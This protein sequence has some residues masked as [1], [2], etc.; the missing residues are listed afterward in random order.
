MTPRGAGTGLAG[1]ATP[2]RGGMLLV[3]SRMDQVLAL[4]PVR[5]FAWVQPGL[6]NARLS[7]LAA[8]HGLLLRARP[9]LAAGEHASAAT[10]PPTP[11]G[12][13]ASSTASPPTTC[14]AWWSCWRDGAVVTLGGEALDAPGADLASVMTGSEGTLGILCEI[15]VRLVPRARGRAHDEPRLRHGRPTP[16]APSRR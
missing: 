13:T 3:T 15:C 9:L 10:W 1:G 8:P 6:V 4:D 11:A 12:R 16:A 7:E 2:Q 5:R 14:S